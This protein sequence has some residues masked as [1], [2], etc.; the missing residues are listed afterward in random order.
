MDTGNL[1]TWFSVSV[2]YACRRRSIPCALENPDASRLWIAPAVLRLLKGARV[3]R[4]RTDFCQWGTPW[5]KRTAFAAVCGD[6]SRVSRLCC[7]TS[8][9][10]SRSLRPHQQLKGI[11]PDG[12]FWTAVAEP[13]P[14]PLC[15]I[16]AKCF[17]DA[18]LSLE[19]R[20]WQHLVR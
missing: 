8:N 14:R 3:A 15:R 5:R 2:M 13:Y 1:L 17:Q 20:K 11:A 6:F 9:C 16:L 10:C 7:R 19:A 12:R 18:L 4:V